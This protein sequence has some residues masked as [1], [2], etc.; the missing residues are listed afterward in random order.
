MIEVEG[1]AVE[2]ELVQCQPWQLPGKPGMLLLLHWSAPLLLALGGDGSGDGVDSQ[3]QD[4]L[5]QE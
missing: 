1:V 3:L 4:G 2:V 5:V